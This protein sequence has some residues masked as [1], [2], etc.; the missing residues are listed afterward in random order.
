MRRA[1]TLHFDRDPRADSLALVGSYETK[2]FASPFRSTI[3]LLALLKEQGQ[4]FE[5]LL[6]ALGA[7]EACDLFS[8]Y[9]VPCKRGRG[10][11]S[12]T[13]LMIKSGRNAWAIEAKWTEPCYATVGEWLA[14]VGGDDSRLS[15][16]REVVN[17]WLDLIRHHPPTTPDETTL[18]TLTYQMIHRAAS[19][20]A[21]GENPALVYLIFHEGNELSSDKNFYRS[22]LSA[23][24]A[25]FGTPASFPFLLVT[26]Q[27]ERSAAFERLTRLKKGDDAT[28]QLVRNALLK[29]ALFSFGELRV[30]VINAS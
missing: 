17:G 30:T 15:N 3:P 27:I 23:L 5:R 29:D 25:A 4:A 11:P 21:A 16:R 1:C 18:S 24:H 19:A 22:Q 28:G 26:M 9:Q 7:G 8:E 20:C 10:K 2:E 6:D 14:E 13:D 12:H